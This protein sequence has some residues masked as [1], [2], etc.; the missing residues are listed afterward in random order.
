[1]NA[2]ALYAWVVLAAAA[3][4]EERHPAVYPPQQL[5]LRFSHRQHLERGA[6]C[7]TC[8]PSVRASGQTADRNLPG[9]PECG[10][11]HDL[12]AA[13]RGEQV[14]PAASCSTCHPGFDPSVRKIPARVELPPATVKFSHQLHLAQKVDCAV[15][16]AGVE[17]ADLATTR[18]LP[19]MKVCL[20]CHDGV[21]ASA[22]CKSCH[23]AL[24]GGRLQLSFISGLLRPMRGNPLGMDH[25]ARFDLDHGAR[26]AAARETCMACHAEH[27]CQACHDA[28]QRPL[29]I[30]PGD[31]LT[32]HPVDARLN[33]TDCSSCHRA[34]SFC[35]A[36]HARAGV[37][38]AIDVH[39]SLRGDAVVHPD[40]FE[41]VTDR[42][43]PR[44]HGVQAARDLQSCI[45]C[46]REESCM[47]CHASRGPDRANPH[48]PGFQAACRSIAAKNDRS[49]VR[50]HT[51]EELR[52]DGCR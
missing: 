6:T 27:Q 45:S 24:P 13:R 47:A 39:P 17:Q 5:P 36:C 29:S 33:A 30:H 28:L 22:E 31:Y 32:L 16:H 4:G 41:F 23:A 10:A 25:G 11:C 26:A 35:V 12:E 8:H 43:S 18:H 21:R 44:H 15:C 20:E 46:H 19:K 14:K 38:S 34:Q 2:A 49:C 1:M 7:S 9:H 42:A 50:C 51:E 40:R 48:G 52:E 3:A 37:M